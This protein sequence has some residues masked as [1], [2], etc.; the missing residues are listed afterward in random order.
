MNRTQFITETQFLEIPS[1]AYYFDGLGAGE[2][3]CVE[4]QGFNWIF[5]YSERGE[6]QGIRRFDSEGEANDHLLATLRKVFRKSPPA[7][8]SKSFPL[9]RSA[10]CVH[11]G[12]LSRVLPALGSLIPRITGQT[13]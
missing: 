2:C 10:P 9:I 5:Y 11:P 6:R 12:V 7:R 3:Y 4:A 8:A 13:F 1:N